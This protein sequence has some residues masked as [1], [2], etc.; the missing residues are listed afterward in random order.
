MNDRTQYRVEQVL[1]RAKKLC[2]KREKHLLKGMSAMCLLLTISL[3]GAFGAV[4]SSLLPGTAEIAQFGAVLLWN[5]ASAYVLIGVL[6]FTA[7][8]AVTV[9]CLRMQR[10]KNCENNETE[11]F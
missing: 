5:G 1:V 4:T 3:V 8:V 7:G 2:L 10:K 9:L 11:K 6:A